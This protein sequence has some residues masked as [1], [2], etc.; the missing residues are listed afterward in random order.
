MSIKE[1]KRL[2]E[3]IQRE[4]NGIDN[5]KEWIQRSSARLQESELA[6]NGKP[7]SKFYGLNHMT[8]YTALTKYIS[9]EYDICDDLTDL[10]YKAL[11]K[12]MNI[13]K[14]PLNNNTTHRNFQFFIPRGFLQNGPRWRRRAKL[15][16]G[17]EFYTICRMV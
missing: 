10:I 7:D 6:L 4:Q 16:I 15:D 8:R 9:E 5:R 17:F 11:V 12:K 2:Q 13:F 1:Q 3:S 14:C